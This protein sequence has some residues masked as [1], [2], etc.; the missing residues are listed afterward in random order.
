M[1]AFFFFWR[2]CKLVKEEIY[3]VEFVETFLLTLYRAHFHLALC[4]YF[5]HYW[6]GLMNWIDIWCITALILLQWNSLR[7]EKKNLHHNAN[8]WYC[9]PPLCFQAECTYNH[10]LFLAFMFFF[11]NYKFDYVTKCFEMDLD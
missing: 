6:H 4:F 10:I 1:D 7:R 5:Y 3:V 8:I 9:F 2:S 11:Y